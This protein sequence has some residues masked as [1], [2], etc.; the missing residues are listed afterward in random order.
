MTFLL[1]A[2]GLAEHKGKEASLVR[3]ARVVWQKAAVPIAKRDGCQK[4]KTAVGS[5]FAILVRTEVAKPR[6]PVT[7]EQVLI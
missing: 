7:A 1:A 6:E 4:R 3:G 5:V 2:S